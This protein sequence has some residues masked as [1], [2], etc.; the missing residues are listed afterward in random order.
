MNFRCRSEFHD[1][2]SQILKPHLSSAFSLRIR[3]WTENPE[4]TEFFVFLI[5]WP[6]SGVNEVFTL[7]SLFAL[8]STKLAMIVLYFWR[9]TSSCLCLI[10]NA[11]TWTEE[12]G[13]LSN[14]WNT[15]KYYKK[16]L[17][18]TVLT[19]FLKCATFLCIKSFNALQKYSVSKELEIILKRKTW[20]YFTLSSVC[21]PKNLKYIIS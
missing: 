12:I 7:S 18:A 3:R 4:L 9:I 8:C 20:F 6:S 10:G 21:K 17:E 15:N 13:Q 1:L 14:H 2:S 16:I 5:F 19:W 11:C